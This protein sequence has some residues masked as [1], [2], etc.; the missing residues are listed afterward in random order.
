MGEIQIKDNKIFCP[1]KNDWHILTPEE[2]VRQKYIQVLINDYQYKIEQMEQ[3]VSLTN[4]HRGNGRARADI[5]VWKNEDEKKS[6]KKPLIV[7]ECKSDN[8]VIREKDYYQGMNY[9]SWAGAKFFVTH[10]SKETR[11]FQVIDDFLPNIPEEILNIPTSSATEKEIKQLLEE[12]KAFSREE[13]TNL[14]KN[15]HN[16]IRNRDAL[17]P[18]SAFDEISKLL[19]IKI[20]FERQD[21][22]GKIF[23]KKYIEEQEE[24]FDKIIKPSL[25]ASDPIKFNSMS[26]TQFLFENTKQ[27]FRE[28]KLFEDSERI[29]I[30]DSTFKDIVSKLEKYNLSKTGDDIKGIAFEKF[31]GQTFRGEIGQ[32]FTPRSVVDFIVDF[33][34]VKEGQKVIDPASG[35]GGFLIRFFQEILGQIEDDIQSKKDKKKEEIEMMNLSE[36]EKAMKLNEE[37]LKLNEEL[38]KR[39]WHLATKCVYGTDKNSRMARTS[40]MNMIMHGDGHGGVHHHDGLI[41]VSNIEENMFDLVITNP[42]FGASVFDEAGEI[43]VLTKYQLSSGKSSQKTEILFIE[44]CLNLLVPGGKMGIVLPEGIL[45]NPSLQFVREFAEGKAKILAVVSLPVETF[46]SSKASV[47]SSII[48][49]QKFSE[50]EK[51][52]YEIISKEINDKYKIE[53]EKTEKEF[54]EKIKVAN[55]DDKKLLKSEL[56]GLID[57]LVLKAKK[58]VKKA[59]N[60]PIFMAEVTNSGITSTGATDVEGNELPLVIEEYRKFEKELFNYQGK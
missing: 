14:L 10:N 17:D 22:Y 21:K 24:N 54:N 15:C 44:R 48:F 42:P 30:K 11:F 60:Y 16:S 38:Q 8:V 58:E 47:K 4:S 20:N 18:A 51:L 12:T 45:N 37:F 43:P 7:V 39:E 32:F 49:L 3:E 33:L 53:I 5:I 56:K 29:K 41:N 50:K 31:L 9:A 57:E 13:F 52:S 36:E 1:L 6:R 25:V 34:E 40:K 55:K 26:Y 27:N 35:S 19:F 59:F 46:I 28:D 23:T 2:L